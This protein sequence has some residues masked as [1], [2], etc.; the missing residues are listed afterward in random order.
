MMI[1]TVRGHFDAAS[2]SAQVEDGKVQSAKVDIVV[3]SIATRDAQRDA[4][5]KSGDFFDAEN[6]PHLHFE[7]TRVE[8]VSGEN[9]RIV[10]NLT[11]RGTTRP[12]TLDAEIA[13]AIK[14]PW[15]NDRIGVSATGLVDRKEFGLNWNVALEAGGVLVG[16]QVKIEVDAE[17]FHAPN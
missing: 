15:G 4:H 7:S 12:M 5:L 17:F 3:G 2:G 6:H 16:D 1:A 9:Y 8:H 13:P 14:D 11:I 10:G